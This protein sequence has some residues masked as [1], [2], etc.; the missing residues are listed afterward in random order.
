M[1]SSSKVPA[2]LIAA[3]L[4]GA[5][6]DDPASRNQ[7]SFG[8]S[9]D[10]EGDGDFEEPGDGDDQ[11][12]HA[13]DGDEG[14]GAQNGDG[15][16]DLAGDE[17]PIDDDWKWPCPAGH[18]TDQDGQCQRVPTLMVLASDTL[19]YPDGV[20]P[21]DPNAPVS[22]TRNVAVSASSSAGDGRLP[23]ETLA[24]GERCR[25][26][27]EFTGAADVERFD[28][29]PISIWGLSVAPATFAANEDLIYQAPGGLTPPF[30]FDQ[31]AELNITAVGT[32]ADQDP[33]FPAFNETLQTL[34]AIRFNH[35]PLVPGRKITFSWPAGDDA[36]V[37]RLDLETRITGDDAVNRRIVCEVR[38]TGGY[39]IPED[40]TAHLLS[41]PSDVV[42]SLQQYRTIR[43]EPEDSDVLIMLSAA[44]W[45]RITY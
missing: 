23:F 27:G 14:D 40:L 37:V 38:D 7:E 39:T 16:G 3:L 35:D 43:I 28:A 34:P 17:D 4:L 32:T 29:G 44:N 2:L 30:H 18:R 9:A 31:G 13:A 6:G 19:S 21:D 12:D 20:N 15:S 25:V 42:V 8:D 11:G 10:L 24:E 22:R 26:Y 36:D 41:N 5:C 1:I 45:T 33:S